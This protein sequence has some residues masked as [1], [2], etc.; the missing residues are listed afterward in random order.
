MSP[1]LTTGAT[2]ERRP[3]RTDAVAFAIQREIE[4]Y[5]DEIDNVD[6][7]RGITVHV[8]LNKGV[9]RL[10]VVTRETEQPFP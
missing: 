2:T 6:G 3:T 10:V 4:R 1:P 5:R 7:L 8:K 9:P